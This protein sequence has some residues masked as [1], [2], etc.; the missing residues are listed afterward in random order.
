MNFQY[1]MALAVMCAIYAFVVSNLGNMRHTRLCNF[2][3]ALSVFVPYVCLSATVYKDVGLYDWNFRN[4]LPVAN[5]S[6]FSFSMMPILIF[7]PRKAKRHVF[8]LISLL[9]VAM[10]G[11]TVLGCLN[12]AVINYK[13]HFHFMLDYV[14]HFA[15]SVFGIYLIKSGQVVPTVKSFIKSSAILLSVATSMLFLNLIFD[16][17]FFGLSLRGKHNIY[18][19]VIV[20]NSYLSALIYYLAMIFLLFVGFIFCKI[21]YKR[22]I[23]SKTAKS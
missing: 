21:I 5:V 11:A 13:F 4:T 6:P 23:S 15:L 10:F 22:N 18:N 3:F 7:I 8:M 1:I 20:D 9:S 2:I 17:A 12:N 19:N 14:A 16:T